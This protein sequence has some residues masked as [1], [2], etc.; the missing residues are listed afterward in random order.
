[1]ATRRKIV[2]EIEEDVPAPSSVL[3][4]I[5]AKEEDDAFT[6][7]DALISE[8]RGVDDTTLSVFRQGVGKNRLAFLFSS[9]P[10]DMTGS[11]IMEKC[12]DEYMGG[13]F[14]M[15]VRDAAGLVKNV[16]FSTEAPKEPEKVDAAPP[17]LGMA[18][19]MT[20]M[21][22]SSDRMAT[23]FTESMRAMAEAFKGQQTPT[24]NPAARSR[25][26]RVG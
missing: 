10:D 1:M 8:F 12:R 6:R 26:G 25:C 15:H 22:A 20:I 14:R 23:M 16:G 4:Q 19:M 13:D 17:G 11:E 24:F 18:E 21:Q 9:T 7:V 5:A 2:E 3:E